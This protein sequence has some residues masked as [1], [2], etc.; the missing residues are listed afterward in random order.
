SFQLEIPELKKLVEPLCLDTDWVPSSR[1]ELNYKKVQIQKGHLITEGR[2]RFE[3]FEGLIELNDLKIFDVF[4]KAPESQFQLMWEHIQLNALGSFLSFGKMNGSF[5]GYAKD[6][7]MQGLLPTQF[8]FLLKA[9][10]PPGKPQV[11]FSSLA[12]KNLVTLL[13]GESF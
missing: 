12:M 7:T 9:E 13:S 10:P 6:V 1:L 2:S 3:L 5:R 8:D 4:T 11:V